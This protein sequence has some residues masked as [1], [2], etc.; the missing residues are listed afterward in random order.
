MWHGRLG[1]ASASVVS[2]VLSNH[3]L[4][5]IPDENDKVCDACQQGKSHQLP[6]PKSTS[7]S[8]SALELVFSHVWGPAPSSVGQF[9]Y[10]VSFIDDYSKFI[11]IYLI[12]HKSNVF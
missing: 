4:S 1:H 9:N 8:T 7:V 11:W 5:F 6:F 12:R 10:Y 3:K 2:R